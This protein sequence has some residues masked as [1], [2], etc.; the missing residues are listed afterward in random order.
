MLP[1]I[2]FLFT[3]YNIGIGDISYNNCGCQ[4]D[5]QLDKC[6]SMGN[7]SEFEQ[8]FDEQVFNESTVIM[9]CLPGSYADSM[10]LVN[11]PSVPSVDIRVDKGVVGSVTLSP[12]RLSSSSVG[13]ISFGNETY[14]SKQITFIEGETL[15]GENVV[16]SVG[17]AP[18]QLNVTHVTFHKL[19]DAELFLSVNN[20]LPNVTLRENFHR[21][22]LYDTEAIITNQDDEVFTVNPLIG[23]HNLS[24]SWPYTCRVYGGGSRACI[25]GPAIVLYYHKGGLPLR[26]Y[27]HSR[28]DMIVPYNS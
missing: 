22:S 1:F 4:S 27:S 8:L 11:F 25:L 9:L 23:T 2:A 16:F 7:V 28:L 3:F 15:V 19:Q 13:T 12:E 5:I 20:E 21:L 17:I 14:P 6:I 26:I 10:S 18:C 24:F